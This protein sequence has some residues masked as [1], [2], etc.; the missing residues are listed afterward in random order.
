[1]S[2]DSGYALRHPG[3]QVIEKRRKGRFVGWRIESA[4]DLGDTPDPVQLHQVEQVAAARESI[5]CH[6]PHGNPAFRQHGQQAGSPKR[7]QRAVRRT[8]SLWKDHYRPIAADRFP[9]QRYGAVAVAA[10]IDDWAVREPQPRRDH[11]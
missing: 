4:E 5:G 6:Q 1:M 11:R 10:W 8:M 3:M 9:E 7:L 2:P